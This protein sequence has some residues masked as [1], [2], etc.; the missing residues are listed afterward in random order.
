MRRTG[1]TLLAALAVAIASMEAG[2]QAYFPPG[3]TPTSLRAS[4]WTSSRLNSVNQ[5]WWK[6]EPAPVELDCDPNPTGAIDNLA[7]MFGGLP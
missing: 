6:T 7:A 5:S 3:A 4:Y 2:A 1:L